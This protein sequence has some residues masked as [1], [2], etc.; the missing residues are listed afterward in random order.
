MIGSRLQQN[1]SGGAVAVEVLV[2][3]CVVVTPVRSP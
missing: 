3:A 1:R 2:H